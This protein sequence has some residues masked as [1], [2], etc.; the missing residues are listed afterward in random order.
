M[1]I[2]NHQ[3]SRS[4]EIL[5]GE[6]I[7]GA[8]FHSV[9][10]RAEKSCWISHVLIYWFH[11]LTSNVGQTGTGKMEICYGVLTKL[12]FYII[13][14]IYIYTIRDVL[15]EYTYIFYYYIILYIYIYIYA[16]TIG[17]HQVQLTLKGLF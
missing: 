10:T 4:S 12:M 11:D 17:P 7:P 14:Y 5:A 16:H 15:S 13:L 8:I 2:L 1:A 6:E 3:R 9:M